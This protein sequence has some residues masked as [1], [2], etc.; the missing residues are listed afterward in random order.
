MGRTTKPHPGFA[1]FVALMALVG[2][3]VALSIDAMLPAFPQMT[4][5]LGLARPNDVQLVVSVLFLGMIV[6]QLFYGPL[7]DSTGRKPAMYLGFGLFIVGSILSIVATTFSVMLIG[8]FLQGL[9]AAGPRTVAIALVR[10]KYEGRDMARVMSFIMSVFI[11]VPIIA[12]AL[13]QGIILLW[14]WRAIFVSFV[15]LAVIVLLWVGIRQPETLP[16]ER[17]RAFSLAGNLQ[18]AVEVFRNRITL[19]YT[20]IS[21]LI[22]GSFYGY[23]NSAQQIFVD[24]YGLGT[25]F[26]IYFAVLALSFGMA[27]I[28]NGR[29]VLYFGMELIMFRAAV[30]MVLATAVA[31]VVALIFQGQPP[32]WFFMIGCAA[33]FFCIG[34]LFGNI[35]AMALQPLGHVAGTASSIVG[36][37]SN[38]IAVAL[39]IFIGQRFDNSVTPLLLGFSL[40]ALLSVVIMHWVHR[41]E[42]TDQP[43]T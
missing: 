11:L 14:H 29:L 5:D 32:L 6:G 24:L 10:D 15:I 18:A 28:V 27:S 26:P 4:E 23:L 19:A 13:G 43:S 36:S 22:A 1:E 40:L 42:T 21:G 2:S 37:L 9:G 12:P 31:A 30:G 39:G 20:V 33:C 35:N 3:L 34:L 7:S 38:L 41:V 17:R 25:K 8:R 16:P